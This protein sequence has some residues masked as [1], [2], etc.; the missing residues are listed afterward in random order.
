MSTD[1]KKTLAFAGV[2]LLL[3]AT[4]LATTRSRDYSA[5]EF[6]K[7][8]GKPF[9]PEFKDPS[10]AAA[11]EVIDFNADLASPTPFKVEYQKSKGWVIPS[12]HDY[13]ADAKKRLADTASGVIDLKKDFIVSDNPEQHEELGVIDPLDTKSTSFKGRGK[14]VTLKDQS[15]SVLA[16]LIV[17]KAVKDHAG[18]RYVRIPGQKRTYGVNINADLSARFGDWIETNLLKLDAFK[19]T[20]VTIDN[21]KVDHERGTVKKGDVLALTR[22]D[23]SSPWNLEPTPP[24]RVLDTAKAGTLTSALGDLKI[25]GVRAKPPGLSAELKAGGGGEGVK[26]S[27][28]SLAA[29]EARGFYM[30]RNG[31]LVSDQGDVY[32]S[33]DEGVVYLLRFGEVTVATGEALT[34]GSEEEEKGTTKK[35]DDAKKKDEPE[36]PGSS[37][38]RFLFVMA[39]FDPTLIPKPE[40]MRLAEA[41]APELPTHVFARDE[42]QIKA[43]DAKLE[44]DR[45]EYERKL[46]EGKK[47]A[48]ELTD[49]FAGWFYVVPGD[50]FRNIVVDLAGLTKDPNAAPPAMPNLPGGPGQGLPPGFNI[51]GMAPGGLPPGH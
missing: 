34:A 8:Q 39:Q 50:A 2:A 26:L 38:N 43:D 20:R 41:E 4:A 48:K 23:G 19:V 47:K 11:L 40:S 37:D 16:D 12:H 32:I 7:D 14:R 17:G 27:Q 10:S 31:Q 5:E 1:L 3:V 25:V 29:L 24:G 36:S 30:T 15:G 21:H 51:P 18:Q 28:G 49:R 33:T 35:S 6:L 45:K 9:F 22:K 13:P 46:E 42:A 44:T